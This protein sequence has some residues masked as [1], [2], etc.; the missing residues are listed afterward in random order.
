MQANQAPVLDLVQFEFTTRETVLRVERFLTT[1]C[2]FQLIV[3]I[4]AATLVR[5]VLLE[6]FDSHREILEERL[7]KVNNRLGEE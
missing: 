6:G 3:G 7:G 5:Y 4:R 2:Q 1:G